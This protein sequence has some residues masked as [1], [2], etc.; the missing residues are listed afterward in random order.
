MTAILVLG[1][2]AHQRDVTVAREPLNETQR[3]FL[4]VILDAPAP[5]INRA[6]HEYFSS[7]GG[8]EFGPGYSARL[9]SPEK[10]LAWS[11]RRHP[12]V[13]ATGRHPAAAK[14][15]RQYP[16]AIGFSIDRTPH[17]FRFEHLVLEYFFVGPT[18]GFS[19]GG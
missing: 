15:S 1:T 3:E 17:R 19:R 6:V 4:A 14:A 2:M 18:R 9:T 8:R 16:K 5:G 12:H 13:V 7:I 10:S 11:Q